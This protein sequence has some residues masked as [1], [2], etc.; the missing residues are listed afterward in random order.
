MRL[1]VE[2]ARRRSPR[3]RAGKAYLSFVGYLL[4]F[5]ILLVGVC[6]IYLIPAM[7]AAATADPLQ[8]KQLAATA[9]LVLAIVLFILFAGLLLTFRIG[10][11]FFPRPTPVAPKRTEY[12]DA[13]AES[14]RRMAEAPREE[15]DDAFG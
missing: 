11:F 10:R 6:R 3:A 9:W 4:G 5:G 1:P 13:W 14:G 7:R 8:R 12:S 15:E 2:K